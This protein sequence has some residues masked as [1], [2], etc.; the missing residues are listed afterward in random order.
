[1]KAAVAPDLERPA[2]KSLPPCASLRVSLRWPIPVQRFTL[3]RQPPAPNEA[4]PTQ[5]L[6][7]TRRMV[8]TG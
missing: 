8:L 7:G 3:S 5:Q 1:M 4:R 6:M 2:L